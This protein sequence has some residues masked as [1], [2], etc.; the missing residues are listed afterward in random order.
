MFRGMKEITPEAWE[1]FRDMRRMLS[2]HL[3]ILIRLVCACV[4]LCV[5]IALAL[6][7]TSFLA[8]PS[9]L[10]LQVGK[11][12]T[13][14]ELFSNAPRLSHTQ[15]AQFWL[16]LTALLCSLGSSL[17]LHPTCQALVRLHRLLNSCLLSVG[18]RTLR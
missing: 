4:H 12:L 11:V 18:I 8:R 13:C 17:P 14:N 3:P 6:F 2:F 10:M 16:F 7:E 15:R 5:C 9:C 1:L